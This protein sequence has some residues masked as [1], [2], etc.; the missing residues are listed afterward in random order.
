M[1]EKSVVFPA[2][3]TPR[4]AAKAPRGTLKLTSRSAWNRPKRW[5]TPATAKA[6]GGAAAGAT[7]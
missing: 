2:P 5:L 7:R 6:G 4:S 3:F 1:S